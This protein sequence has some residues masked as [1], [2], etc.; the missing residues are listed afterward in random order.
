MARPRMAHARRKWRAS[1]ASGADTWKE[2]TRVD[3]DAREG[4]HMARG[5]GSSRAHRL[6]LG[7][8]IGAVMQ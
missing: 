4:C 6:G 7:Y 5:A 3:A 8:R 2:A 1:A